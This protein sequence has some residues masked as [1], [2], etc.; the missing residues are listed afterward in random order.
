MTNTGKTLYEL[1]GVDLSLRK[2][3][4]RLSE[5]TIELDNH[6]PVRK[7][8]RIVEMAEAIVKPL[9]TDLRD[10]EL[11]VQTT[12]QK[13]EASEKRLYS[14]AVSNPKELQ[15]IEQNIASLKRRSGELEDRQ[16][17]LML[18]IETAEDRLTSANNNLQ[19]VIEEAAASNQ[20]LL[21]EKDRLES[22]IASLKAQRD[23]ITAGLEQ[24]QLDLYTEMQSKMA[25]RPIATLDDEQTC[26]ICGVQQTTVHAQAIRQSDELMRCT[27]CKRIL[28]AI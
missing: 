23:T 3:R 9:Q 11:Q 18:E 7:A 28:I 5:I 12:A 14:G 13:R 17:E 25:F 6:A 21:S 19:T 27:S 16:L 15:D 1:Q 22:E 8:R 26:S 10:L 4:K 2:H 24:S 20:D